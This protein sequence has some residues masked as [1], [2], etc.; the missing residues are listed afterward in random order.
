MPMMARRRSMRASSSEITSSP[1]IA[2]FTPTIICPSSHDDDAIV[3][4]SCEDGKI[5][6]VIEGTRTQLTLT[7]HAL[8]LRTSR[9]SLHANL[10]ILC[11]AEDDAT[12]SSATRLLRDT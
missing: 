2:S 4:R 12:V 11:S 5:C 3:L 9:L 6:R 1:L 7:P 8:V 10:S